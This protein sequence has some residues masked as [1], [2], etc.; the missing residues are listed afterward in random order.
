MVALWLNYWPNCDTNSLIFLVTIKS[1]T[2]VLNESKDAAEAET[3]RFKFGSLA[4]HVRLVVV[5]IHQ[6]LH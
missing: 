3:A 5:D 1:L 6:G 4:R 2:T